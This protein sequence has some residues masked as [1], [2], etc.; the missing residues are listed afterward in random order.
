MDIKGYITSGI[1]ESYALGAASD[2]EQREVQCLTAIYPEIANALRAL[3]ADMETFAQSMAV[4]PPSRLKENILRAIQH[5]DQDKLLQETAPAKSIAP[6]PEEN[7]MTV[8]RSSK[9][10][11][12]AAASLAAL[13][14]L[15]AIFFVKQNN[16]N[17]EMV[18]LQEQVTTATKN[19]SQQLELNAML[20]KSSTRKIELK[21]TE[22]EPNAN[23]S[24]FWNAETQDVAFKVNNLPELPAGKDYQLWAIVDGKPTDMG[25]IDFHDALES[26]KKGEIKVA[27]PQA[28]A[29]TIEPKGGSKDPTLSA[30][31]VLGNT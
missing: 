25:V 20:S 15:T 28:F 19:A 1:L 6:S 29:I 26:V 7:S 31:V 17:K 3:E 11:W 16:Q 22:N 27:G 10:P 21:G 13:I 4:E 2:Q 14:A 5:I 23:V 8:T 9:R 24:V 12:L 18:A 30:M